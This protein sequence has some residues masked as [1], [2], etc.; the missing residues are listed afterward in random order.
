MMG[1][2]NKAERATILGALRYYQSNVL[3]GH[4]SMPEDIFDIVTDGNTVVALVAP[5]VDDLCDKFINNTWWI[6]R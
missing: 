3:D 4:V 5:E 6:D 2:L 1:N